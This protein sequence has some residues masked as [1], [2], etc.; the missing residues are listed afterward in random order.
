MTAGTSERE[1]RP[2]G[3]LERDVLSVLWT[4]ESPLTASQ[5]RRALP[6]AL[7]YTTVSTILVRL[8]AKGL[9]K[10][11]PAGRAYAYE[12]VVSDADLAAERMRALLA[13]THDHDATLAQFVTTLSPRDVKALRRALGQGA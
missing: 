12:A 10:R 7:A 6:D 8:A 9:L 2:M 3:A 11:T 13:S 4:S 1:R 5:V